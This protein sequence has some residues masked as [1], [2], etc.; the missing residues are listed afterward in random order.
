VHDDPTDI[1]YREESLSTQYFPGILLI[2]AWCIA[3]HG[4][5]VGAWL[6]IDADG[7]LYVL[8]SPVGFE[9]LLRRHPVRM[10]TEATALEYIH[11]ALLLQGALPAD[12]VLIQDTVRTPL[13]VAQSVRLS[14][15]Q[16][17][18]ARVLQRQGSGANGSLMVYYAAHNCCTLW[19][20]TAILE[21]SDGELISLVKKRTTTS[22]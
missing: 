6:A 7:V 20:G 4:D 17:G 14:R 2:R 10:L 13:G 22:E 8:G 9:L 1:L 16:I 12:A 5:S 18:V 21:L 3:E 19:S 11:W 15:T